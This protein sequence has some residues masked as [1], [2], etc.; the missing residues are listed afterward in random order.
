MRKLICLVK[1]HRLRVVG[2][3]CNGVPYVGSDVLEFV[4]YDVVGRCK[5]CGDKRHDYGRARVAYFA[6]PCSPVL[7]ST[8][9]WISEDK[10]NSR[11]VVN[12]IERFLNES[13]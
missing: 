6:Q 2:M 10:E 7:A 3:T 13:C 5:R 12:N 8:P 1:G 11:I 4:D 9:I